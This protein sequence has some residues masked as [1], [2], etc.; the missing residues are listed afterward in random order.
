MLT[1]QATAKATQIAA[2]SEQRLR[3]EISRLE[4]T[5]GRLSHEVE[6]MSR[7][8]ESE[9]NRLR[10]AL[11]DILR[12]VDQNVQPNRHPRRPRAGR[13][14]QRDR[15]PHPEPHARPSATVHP[16][17]QPPGCRAP[18]GRAGRRAAGH[19]PERRGTEMRPTGAVAADAPTSANAPLPL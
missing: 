14:G 12:W 10:T 6:T 7:H 8:L 2:E 1:E 16:G 4:E 17:W 3:E 9:R 19:R 5:R 13:G 18:T 15:G 11:G